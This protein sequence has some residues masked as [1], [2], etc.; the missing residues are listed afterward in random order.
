MEHLNAARL[1]EFI[2]F[3]KTFYVPNNCV[4][5]IAGDIDIEETKRQVEQYFAAIPKGTKPIPRPNI[6]EKPLGGEVR[7]VIED[8]IQLP[9][10]IQAYRAPKQGSEEYYAFRMLSTILSG[11]PSSR[12]NKT[13]VD[14][15]QMA[16]AALALPFFNEDAGLFLNYAIAAMGVKPD[17]L[18]KVVDSVVA[19][20]QT[21]LV[22]EREFQKVRNQIETSFV[23]ANATMAGVAES[24]ANYEVYFGDANLI[25]T[26]LA[27][28]NK[29]TRGDI[30]N[31]AKKY[32]NKDNRVVLYYVPKGSK[33]AASAK[34]G[35]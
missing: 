30:L 28:Y 22:S 14:E 20:L 32:L 24:L 35:A 33:S 5:S 26:E 1:N 12:M 9:A 25:N 21:G 34:P 17:A 18:E 15:R 16:V 27:R 31:V 10:V 11:G 19:T 7:D 29:V 2:D 6:T 4:L 8:N 13:I 23:T 3:Y